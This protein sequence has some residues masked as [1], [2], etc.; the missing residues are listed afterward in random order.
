MIRPTVI[1]A[2][3]FQVAW[4]DAT[5]FLER[6]GWECWNLVVH[7]T[8]VV[9]FDRGFHD[10]VCMFA[11]ASDLLQPKHVAYTIF[12]HGLY[13]QAD[14]AARL[15]KS[16]D[17]LYEWTRR[18]PRASWGTYFRRM[19][20]YPFEGTVIN[21]LDAI[22]QA[23]STRKKDRKAAYTIVIQRPGAE[24][25]R[26]LGA[27]C[28]NYIAVQIAPGVPRILS[29]L[30]VY[31]NHDFLK[32]AYGNYWGLCNLLNFLANETN[33]KAGSLT[34]ISSHAYVRDKKTQL[35]KLLEGI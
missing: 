12:P 28:L 22:I 19:T 8:N 35:K 5:K 4:S 17:K 16:Y 18:R 2:S 20:S 11:A 3:S 29:L 25:I 31:R 9:A 1:E 15:Y 10:K 33:S 14:S 23:I 24:T 27:P 34:C 13:R 32:K 30:C 21:Q 6:N 26:P 7:I